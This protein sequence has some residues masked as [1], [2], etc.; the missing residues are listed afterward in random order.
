MKHFKPLVLI[1]TAIISSNVMSCA[2]SSGL[3]QENDYFQY[4][5]SDSQQSVID[6]ASG[7]MWQR[8]VIG[9]S[10]NN[11]TGSCD[12]A[13]TTY[14]DWFSALQEVTT[15]NNQTFDGY[16]DWRMPNTK[17]LWSLVE[18]G[19][20][21]PS[22]NATRF[23]DSPAGF[24]Y[25]NTPTRTTDIDGNLIPAGEGLKVPFS[26]GTSINLTYL[27]LVRTYN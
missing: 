10:Y 1:S 26:F 12:S 6:L 3:E 27:R 7:L 16:G 8:C 5:L 22:I 13:G 21:S 9:Q 20:T 19:C 25:S 15:I 23:P 11:A 18:T 14:S 24:L 2:V 17:E 4:E